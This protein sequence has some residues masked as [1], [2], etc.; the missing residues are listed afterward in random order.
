M[1]K[2]NLHKKVNDD[3]DSFDL[4]LMNTVNIDSEVDV[5]QI[6]A[7]I[8]V[9]DLQM[10]LQC[11]DE[12]LK[13]L[14]ILNR[15]KLI[16]LKSLEVYINSLHAKCTNEDKT[17]TVEC[18][19]TYPLA[20][21]GYPYFKTLNNNTCPPNNDVNIKSNNGEIWIDYMH[22][23]TIWSD[24]DIIDLRRTIS[25]CYY[26]NQRNEL[27]NKLMILKN[28]IKLCKTVS[29]TKQIEGKIEKV[30]EKIKETET[31]ELK[32]YPKL[33]STKVHID[34]YCISEVDLRGNISH[35]NLNVL[36]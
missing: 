21:I 24:S 30:K 25:M 8:N 29:E 7:Y 6:K 27:D 33:H 35:K 13:R 11:K 32:S 20:K 4:D 18:R 22:S 15:Y 14:M 16:Q 3:K 28:K 5:N 17:V 19:G 31:C 23:P 9:K 1:W 2:Y 10:I 34:W 12:N 26:K 36:S